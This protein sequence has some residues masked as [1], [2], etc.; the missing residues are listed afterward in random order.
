MNQ[1]EKALS[2]FSCESY[3]ATLSPSHL[4]QDQEYTVLQKLILNWSRKNENQTHESAKDSKSLFSSRKL[5]DTGLTTDPTYPIAAV[6]I[7]VNDS[8]AFP[9]VVAPVSPTHQVLD[10]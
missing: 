2:L 5:L 6:Q 3:F 10:D 8:K 4:F 7:V 1:I 9:G